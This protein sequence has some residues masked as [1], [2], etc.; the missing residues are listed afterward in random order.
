[1]AGISKE[2]FIPK[3]LKEIKSD[4]TEEIR[5]IQTQ[6]GETPFLDIEDDS[7]VAQ[8]IS[9]FASELEVAWGALADAYAQFDP[10][11]NTGAGQ[12]GTVQ[13]NG[14]TRKKGS[15]TKIKVQLKGTEGT[16]VPKG[17]LIGTQDGSEVYTLDSTVE[18]TN[19]EPIAVTATNTVFGAKQPKPGSITTIFEPI[20]G[21]NSV[22]NTDVIE[23]GLDEET[24]AELRARQQQSTSL[25]SYR[26]VEAVWAAVSNLDGVE[27]CRVYQNSS[28]YPE[29]DRGIPFKEVA[30]IVVGGDDV[31]IA[32]VLFYRF[33][34]G[35]IGFGTTSIVFNDAQ[36]FPYTISFSRP[37]TIDIHIKM[38]L[39]VYDSSAWSSLRPT[40]IKHSIIEYAKYNNYSKEGFPPGADVILTRLYTPINEVPGFSVKELYIGT[41]NENLT[42]AD[43]PIAWDELA[44]FKEENITIDV[45]FT[46]EG[47]TVTF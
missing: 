43:V 21:W 46:A 12:S 3:T 29:D 36:G 9:V 20:I 37:K 10:Q 6:S 38:K 8:L 14:I 2:G 4:L 18:I 33:P 19:E 26:Q 7:I 23:L 34:I 44:T 31:E 25:T 32:K 5:A 30:T 39:E 24:D 1:M 35:Q 41:S 45:L 15:F 22:T 13:L 11:M 40:E 16:V 17:S 47:R 27:Y 28:V 42:A